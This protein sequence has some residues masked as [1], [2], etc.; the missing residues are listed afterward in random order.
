MEKLFTLILSF[1]LAA[2][3]SKDNKEVSTNQ[4]SIDSTHIIQETLKDT[5][6]FDCTRGDPVPSFNLTV[7]PNRQF[8]LIDQTTAIETVDL[9]NNEKIIVRH[10]GCEYYVLTYR[11]ET[12]R[13]QA[14]TSKI[15]FWYKKTVKLLSEIEQA[16]QSPIDIKLG[17]RAM[18]NYIDVYTEKNLGDEI[19]F[20]D[21]VIRQFVTLDRIE[22]LENNRFAIEVTFAIG[23]L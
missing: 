19:D 12:S 23:P 8:Q 6:D 20:A 3:F 2:C 11:F 18:V 14:D 21:S 15:L 1:F 16:N 13:F 4:I 9:D 17:L 22:Q 5:I 10:G 7:F